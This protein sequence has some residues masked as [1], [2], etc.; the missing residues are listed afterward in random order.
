[1]I[2]KMRWGFDA[3]QRRVLGLIVGLAVILLT[4]L[5]GSIFGFLLAGY[6]PGTS[7]AVPWPLMLAGYLAAGYLIIRKARR[8]GLYPGS[9]YIRKARARLA[10]EDVTIMTAPKRRAIPKTRKPRETV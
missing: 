8:K 3:R 9:P 10:L 1:M 6:I 7:W 2:K 4:P 5:L